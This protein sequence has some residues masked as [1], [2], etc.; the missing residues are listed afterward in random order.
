MSAASLA[1]PSTAEPA[2]AGCPQPASSGSRRGRGRT[3]LPGMSSGVLL[4]TTDDFLISSVRRLC[5]LAG[6]VC[7][8]D[9][10]SNRVRAVWRDASAVLVGIDVA[11]ALAAAG[12]PRHERLLVLAGAEIDAAGWRAALSLGATA[13][14]RLPDEEAALVEEVR[15]PAAV[16]GQSA[17]VI[18]VVGGCG[19]AGASTFAA[20][21]ALTAARREAAVLI[22]GDP[23]GGGLDV[24]LGAESVPGLRWNELAATRGRLDP[25]AFASAICEVA[26]MGLVSWGRSPSGVSLATPA[27]E[28]VVDAA[29]RAFAVVVLD[30]ARAAGGASDVLLDSAEESVLVVRADV[31]AVSAAAAVS[32]GYG[33]R[34]RAPRLV[35]RD[36][37]G[38]RL[39]ANDV[40]ASLG[41]PLA[42]T[43]RSE[44]SVQAAADRGEPPVRRGRCALTQACE[45]VLA[46]GQ[47]AEADAAS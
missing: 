28:A 1:A 6:A 44:P 19:G 3:D 31:R 47:L 25:A 24:L 26:G 9:R 42:A 5:A 8:V 32:A 18:A 27:M 11:P 29:R 35:V 22:D 4:V 33:R 43:L 38:A 36:P 46:A 2:R 34:L 41:V 20:A 14:L 7:E 15:A 23:L 39:S 21:L 12:L 45:Q 40:A 37:G 30:V 13:V 17:R 16:A 10:D